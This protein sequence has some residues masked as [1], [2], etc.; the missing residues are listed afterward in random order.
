MFLCAYELNIEVDA[1]R[2]ELNSIDIQSDEWGTSY[3]PISDIGQET[4]KFANFFNNSFLGKVR[5]VCLNDN[6]EYKWHID[7]Y[8]TNYQ[9]EIPNSIQRPATI[10]IL[11]SDCNN[12]TTLFAHDLQMN[13]HNIAKPG[14]GKLKDLTIVDTFVQNKKPLLINTGVW[15]A[16]K[17]SSVRKIASFQ[18]WPS[19]S[20]DGAVHFCKNKGVLIER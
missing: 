19:I 11:L 3:I 20:F 7:N 10:N 9:D 1:L 8:N 6:T 12:D 16:I 5:I 4:T 13:K 18:F 17:T 15:H 2:L 14:Y